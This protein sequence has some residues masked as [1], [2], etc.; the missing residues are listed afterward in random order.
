MRETFSRTWDGLP[1]S[2]ERPYGASV[3]VW[4]AG[5][6]R[7]E[8][9]I[10]H[11]RHHGPAYEGDWAWTP[12]SGARLPGEPVEACARRELT[13]E[14]GLGALALVPTDCG[15]DEWVLYAAEAP[16]DAEVRLDA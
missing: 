4:R 2:A 6:G 14:T 11:R 13:E 8:W 7:R 16:M 12:P 15:N 1:V 3:L 10:L 9:L 5:A